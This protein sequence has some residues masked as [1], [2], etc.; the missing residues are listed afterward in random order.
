MTVEEMRCCGWL[1]GLKVLRAAEVK[2]LFTGKQVML[3]GPDRH[4]EKATE[5]GMIVMK[6][7]VKV[8]RM[9]N[10]IEHV[11]IREYPGKVWAVKEGV[12]GG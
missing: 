2:T 8:V 6:G 4:G 7:N 9:W 11:R 12:T 5:E 3:I 1:Q 10:R